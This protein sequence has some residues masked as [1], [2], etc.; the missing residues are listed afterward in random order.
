MSPEMVTAL[1]IAASTTW[2]IAFQLAE[3]RRR[4]VADRTEQA[5]RILELMKSLDTCGMD[6]RLTPQA[7]RKKHEE[8]IHRLQLE[9]RRGA[10]EFS[11]RSS[12]VESGRSEIM[13][14]GVP[15]AAAF[16]GGLL[17]LAFPDTDP[18][19]IERLD[20]DITAAVLL[21]LGF[22]GVLVVFSRWSSWS[23]RRMTRDRAGLEEPAHAITF[24]EAFSFW[25]TKRI[26][27]RIRRQQKKELASSC[28]EPR[29]EEP[30]LRRTSSS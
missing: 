2:T 14:W 16:L 10:A 25:R 28:R 5:G 27:R 20:S 7:A 3:L 15:F 30:S 4:R 11:L 13:I 12:R 24:S 1:V 23:V 22:F 21:A 29:T 19:S 8:E 6:R 18:H 26:A 9:I 17:I